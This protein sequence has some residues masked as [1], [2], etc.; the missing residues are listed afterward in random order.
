MTKSRLIRVPSPSSGSGT[1]LPLLSSHVA[2]EPG[3]V[4]GRAAGRG[5]RDLR[6]HIHTAFPTPHQHPPAAFPP[7]HARNLGG[8]GEHRRAAAGS[9]PGRRVGSAPP[10]GRGRGEQR[11]GRTGELAAARGCA[12]AGARRG[13]GGYPGSGR[14]WGSLRSREPH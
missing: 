6:P 1:S 3:D 4:G 13:A 5:P 8:S 14:G 10:A 2:P 7:P 12:A 9:S 11:S